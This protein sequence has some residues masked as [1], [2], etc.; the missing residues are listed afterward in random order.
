MS[1]FNRQFLPLSGRVW[2]G[3]PIYSPSS[4]GSLQEPV[5]TLL[6][7]NPADLAKCGGGQHKANP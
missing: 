2:V 1:P 4:F 7:Q 6:A 3:V 5:G